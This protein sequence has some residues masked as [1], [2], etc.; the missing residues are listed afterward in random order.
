VSSETAA[1]VGILNSIAANVACEKEMTKISASVF[2]RSIGKQLAGCL[3]PQLRFEQESSINWGAVGKKIG[4]AL[5]LPA[6][7]GHDGRKT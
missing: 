3:P 6:V 2:I 7:R 5:L 4:S 1:G